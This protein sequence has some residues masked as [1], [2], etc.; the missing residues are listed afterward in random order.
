ME[1]DDD[2]DAEAFNVRWGDGFE[3]SPRLGPLPRCSLLATEEE[4]AEEGDSNRRD[5]SKGS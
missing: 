3:I 5:S 4:E 2:N 1:T